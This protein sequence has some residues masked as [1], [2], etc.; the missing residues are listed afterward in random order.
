[1]GTAEVIPSISSSTVAWLTGIYTDLLA[2]IHAF[3]RQACKLFIKGAWQLLWKHIHGDFLLPVFLGII[4]SLLSTVQL[5][6][7]LLAQYPIEIRSFFCGL[8]LI[9]VVAFF[10][11]INPITWL[12]YLYS[13]LGLFIACLIIYAD[14]V[15]TSH[16]PWV[17]FLSGVLAFCAMILPGISGSFLL[18]ILGQ[19]EYLLHAVKN[20]S[21]SIL[22]IFIAGGFL[23]LFG[24]SKLILQLFRNYANSIL[25][26]VAGFMLGSLYQIW[27]WKNSLSAVTKHLDSYS[28]SAQNILPQDFQLF[29]L[30]AP[31]FVE[32][33]V[34]FAIGCFAAILLTRWGLKKSHQF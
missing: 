4:C 17:L 19:Y 12:S 31:N 26:I 14:L 10:R 33:L 27:P 7:Y 29:S 28:G 8:S 13:L 1:M 20:F 6:S 22:S 3:D 2:T 21:W 25:P 11:Q 9:A 32:A 24:V 34:C 18:L 15:I 23:G 30:Q 16:T 5:V